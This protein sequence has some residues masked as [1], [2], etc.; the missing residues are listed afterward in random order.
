[1]ALFGRKKEEEP[2]GAGVPISQVLAMKAQGM[3]NQQIMNQLRA[4]GYPLSQIRDA[5]SQAEIK[6]AVGP[7]M[8]P[9]AGPAMQGAGPAMQ[10]PGME[11]LPPLPEMGM[12]GLEMPPGMELPELPGVPEQPPMPGYPQAPVQG[13]PQAPAMPAAP[14]PTPA[15]AA[16]GTEQLVDELQRIIEGI[17]EDK[18][19]AVEDKVAMLDV[20]KSKLE[21]RMANQAEQIGALQTRMDDFAKSVLGQGEEYQKAMTDVSAQMQ[22]IE[23]LMGKLIPSLSEEIK[24]LRGIVGE[25]KE[26]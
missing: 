22:A 18:W 25:M 3:S 19:K 23:K 17:I 13:Y 1:M 16:M 26:R 15:A 24:E 7:G 8:M 6:S 21:E 4:Q 12:E 2:V 9:G 10:Q 11:G 14:M 5:V 20:W